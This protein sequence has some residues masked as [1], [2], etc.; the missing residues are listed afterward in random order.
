LTTIYVKDI[1]AQT[2]INNI[3]SGVAVTV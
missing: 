1:D 3:K 2:F